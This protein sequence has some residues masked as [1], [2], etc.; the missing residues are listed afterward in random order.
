MQL[1]PNANKAPRM[2]VM[3][4]LAAIV[5]LQ[6]VW[7]SSPAVQAMLPGEAVAGI[8]GVLAVLGMVG[9]LVAQ[10]SVQP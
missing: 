4:A 6:G 3:Q 8:T 2:F 9:R 10:R 1:I 7:A 5:T